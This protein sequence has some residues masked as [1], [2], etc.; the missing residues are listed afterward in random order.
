MCFFPVLELEHIMTWYPHQ[1]YQ[2]KY[3]RQLVFSA[4]S[5]SWLVPYQ[6]HGTV[7]LCQ[8]RLML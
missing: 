1:S 5:T 2:R 4:L 6:A 7:Q 3:N 8:V